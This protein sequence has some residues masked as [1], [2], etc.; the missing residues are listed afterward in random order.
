[1]GNHE[2]MQASILKSK[3]YSENIIKYTLKSYGVFFCTDIEA[4]ISKLQES[5]QHLGKAGISLVMKEQG[6]SKL[7]QKNCFSKMRLE[8]RYN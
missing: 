5:Q 8:Y 4:M 2:Q 6:Q 7:F 1:M 3:N